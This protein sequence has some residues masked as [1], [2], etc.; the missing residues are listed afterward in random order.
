MFWSKWYKTPRPQTLLIQA[1]WSGSPGR[2]RGNLTYQALGGQTMFS[3]AVSG[4]QERIV[5]V[6]G[7]LSLFFSPTSLECPYSK[8]PTMGH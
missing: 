8:A 2:P 4:I 7:S 6:T 1:T 3:E 5:G